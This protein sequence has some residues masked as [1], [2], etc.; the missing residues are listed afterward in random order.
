MFWVVRPRFTSRSS[1][2]ITALLSSFVGESG[3]STLDGVT[4]AGYLTEIMAENSIWE[5]EMVVV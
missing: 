1:F 4:R 2:G 3:L 5:S